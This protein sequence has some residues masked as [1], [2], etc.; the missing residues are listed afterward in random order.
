[1][2]HQ[3]EVEERGGPRS[4]DGDLAHVREVEEAGPRARRAVLV[5]LG[6]V[7]GHVPGVVA[8]ARR[9]LAAVE[10]ADPVLFVGVELLHWEGD[11]RALPLDALGRALGRSPARW[12]VNLVVLD[13]AQDP[14][15]DWLRH[16]VRPF[17]QHA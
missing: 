4:R 9:C 13:V 16:K 14:V 10:T 7:E 6:A 8:T 17:Y 5:A 2:F 11:P 3:R 12:P 1:M 15:A